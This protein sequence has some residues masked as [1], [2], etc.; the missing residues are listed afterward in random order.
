[1]KVVGDVL[2]ASLPKIAERLANTRDKPSAA[3]ATPTIPQ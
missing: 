2:F 3:P 1:M